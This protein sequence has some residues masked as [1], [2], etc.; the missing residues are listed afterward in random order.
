MSFM[1]N[2]FDPRKH[3]I[4]KPVNIEKYIGGNLPIVRSSYEAKFCR[5]LD[6]NPNIIK[7]N[8][9]QIEIRYL[10]PLTNKIRRYFPD[11]YMQALDKT[12]KT[13]NYIIEIKPDKEIRP[14]KMR[15]RKKEKTFLYE[16]KTWLKNE[17]KWKAA[18]HWCNAN[19]FEF[20]ILTEKEL[21][22]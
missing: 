15:G 21:F 8:S 12:G 5:W 19:N 10:D 18:I 9:E 2:I 6:M 4:Y 1:N 22:K 3:S 14:P 17:A 20:K 11:F 7:W 16:Q 13:K